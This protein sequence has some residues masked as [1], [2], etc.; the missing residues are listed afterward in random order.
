MERGSHV[1]RGGQMKISMN[2]HQS[3]GVGRKVIRVH[4]GC[5]AEADT[6][7]DEKFPRR[8]RCWFN[9]V[10]ALLSSCICIVQIFSKCS[11]SYSPTGGAHESE[12]SSE[13][14]GIA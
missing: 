5:A 4:L 2:V 10:L 11:Y 6:V 8:F 14:D 13:C 7:A 9:N 12:Y 1:S 3:G